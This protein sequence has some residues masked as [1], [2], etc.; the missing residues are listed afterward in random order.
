MCLVV[1][2]KF[3]NQDKKDYFLENISQK[4][5]TEEKVS[6]EIENITKA[7]HIPIVLGPDR[8]K[9][10]TRGTDNSNVI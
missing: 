1:I 5:I 8:F 10:K 9:G 6:A 4:N 3:T 7:Q 2:T